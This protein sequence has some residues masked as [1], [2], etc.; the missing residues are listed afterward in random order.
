M[1]TDLSD[2][3]YN[4]W[5]QYPEAME[6]MWTQ[7]ETNN[8]KI[9]FAILNGEISQDLHLIRSGVILSPS[10]RS[11]NPLFLVANYFFDR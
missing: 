1:A 11:L 7:N 9:D 3:C 4:Q 5:A 10:S 8:V 2:G 6:Y